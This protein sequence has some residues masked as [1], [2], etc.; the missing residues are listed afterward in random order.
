MYRFASFNVLLLERRHIYD[1]A[2]SNHVSHAVIKRIGSEL[3]R[4]RER[5]ND[6]TEE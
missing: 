4:G 3:K 5:N 2:R 6:T 1:D